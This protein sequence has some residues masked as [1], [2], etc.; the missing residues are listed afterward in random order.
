MQRKKSVIVTKKDITSNW[1]YFDASDYTLGRLATKIATILMGK[2]KTDYVDYLNN[3]DK[4]VVINSKDIKVT[5]KKESD[6]IYFRH[7]GNIQGF[8]EEP[9]NYLREFKPN[10][11]IENAVKG[12][13]PK[14]MLRD[15][16]MK[17]LFLYPNGDHKQTAQEKYFIKDK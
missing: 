17:N 14:N 11:I 7:T 6:K 16:R 3:G 4:V 5:G 12:M 13:L 2:H 10:T 9:L 1:Y 8:R 15:E